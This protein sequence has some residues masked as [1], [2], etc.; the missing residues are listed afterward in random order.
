[1]E[2]YYLNKKDDILK[3]LNSDQKNGLSSQEAKQRLEKYGPN[4]LAEKK[5]K[6]FF[7]KLIE[8]LLDPMVIILLVAAAVSSLQGDMV[9]TLIIL[10]IVVLNSGLSLYQEG[11]AENSLK[12][13]QNMSAPHAKVIRDGRIQSVPAHDLVPGDI[14]SLETGDIVP[15]DIR[16][17]DSQNLSSDES[18][19][20]GESVPVDKDSNIELENDVEIGDRTN[21]LHSSSIIT[22]GRGIGIVAN[23]GHNTEIGKIATNIQSTEEE[24]SPLQLKLAKLSKT[25]GYLVVGVSII[26]FIVGLLRPDLSVLD[27]LMTAVSLAVAAI[28]E[29]LAAVVTIV[30]SIG[31]NRMS[32]K[33]AIVKKL[34]AVETL[35]T[36]T[37]IAS[38]KTGTLTQN[39]MTV[40]TIFTNNQHFDV[41]GVGYSPEGD[42]TSNEQKVNISENKEL[43]MLITAAS[44]DSDA[45]LKHENNKWDIIGDPTEGALI[46][47]SE[48]AGLSNETLNDEFKRVKEYPFDSTRKMMT[49]FHENY[50]DDKFVSFTKGAPDIMIDKSSKIILNG[51]VVDFTPELKQELLDKNNEYARQAL[52]V[53]AFS[54]RTWDKLPE[55]KDPDNIE[56]D[57][58]FIGLTG[59]I[60]PA[61]PEA[62]EAIKECKTAGIIPMMITG[63]YL[64]T[65]LAIGKDLGIADSDDQ[66]I[67]GKELNNMTPEQLREIVKTKRIFA[68]VSPENKVQIVTALK[69]NGEI[70]AMTGDGVNDAPAIKKADIG[71]AMGITGTDVA[72]G[73]A[74]VILTDDNFATIVNAVEEGRIIYAN[75]KKFV[76][77]LL[78]CN[79]GE[80][81]IMLIAMVVGAPIP[82][83]VIQLLWLNLVTDS[84]PALALG[85]EKGEPDIMNN[86]P[87]KTDEQ[88]VDK[89]IIDNIIVQAIA[90]TVSTLGAFYISLNYLHAGESGEIQ[91][92][93]AQT[94]A[95]ITL[96]LAELLRAF[97]ARSEK[98]TLF[99]LGIFTNKSLVHAFIGSFILTLLVVYLPFVQDI[100]NSVP[101]RLIDWAVIIPF[102]F[103]PFVVGEIHKL[104]ER[105]LN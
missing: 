84:F 4:A 37:F 58:I 6:S 21:Y 81:L 96:I 66:A 16:L 67:M 15:A 36:T 50:F 104:I 82:L 55:D 28:P 31:M 53:L 48:K 62:K 100:F 75:I 63:D 94:V 64:E 9:E 90:I 22:R 95:F 42:I 2:K 25:L 98:Y 97:S 30:L 47:L 61:R 103:L 93:A 92:H 102:A 59:M 76:S 11:K 8:Q 71:I 39:E 85:V 101:L 40:K 23:T 14:V 89:T 69:E 17:L 27:S 56:S 20:T 29:G 3:D 73:T 24:A 86:P 12:A 83:T 43:E 99:E 10:A 46:T 60:D 5:G 78:T 65:A 57:M 45:K 72:K 52:R 68:R 41:E 91:L 70:T 32:K 38:D 105:K 35:G 7:A 88:I 34:L 18:S 54:Y 1:M 80:V 87:R 49:T 77:F 51:E 19:L 74:E 44:L 26:V 13:L 79:I 33:N